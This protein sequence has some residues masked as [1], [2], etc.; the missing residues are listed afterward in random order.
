MT[1]TFLIT[2]AARGIGLALTEKA[3][4]RGDVVIAAVRDPAAAEKLRALASLTGKID[5]RQ[6]DVTDEA[7]VAALAEGLAGRPID[8]LVANAGVLNAYSGIE[9]GDHDRAAWEAVLMTNVYGPYAT[10]RALLANL[11]AGRAKKI[12]IISSI[13]ASSARAPGRAYPY[14]ASKAAATNLARNLAA[15][16]KPAGIAVGAFH[17][18]W[19]RTE[20]GGPSADISVDESADGLLSRFDALSLETTGVFEDYRGEAIPF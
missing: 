9:A 14:R 5:L 13:M 12:A 4:A 17:P 1:Q 19:V 18:G 10:T 6:A 16:L 3:V 20:M 8:V 7:S 11:E 2:G 15:D